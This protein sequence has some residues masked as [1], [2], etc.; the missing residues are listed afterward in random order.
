[1]SI[2]S[3]C[4]HRL[5][6][7]C[8]GDIQAITDIYNCYIRLTDISFETDELT[9]EQ[10][11]QRIDSIAAEYPY[12]VAE[13]NGQVVGY[14]YAHPWKERAAYS[15]TLETTVYVAPSHH[16]QGIGRQLMLR[17]IDDCRQQGYHALIACITA[18]NDASIALHTTLGFMQ[19][20]SFKDVGY[21]FGRFIDVVDYELL[22]G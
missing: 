14:C 19:V 3:K 10:M 4:H 11:G 13:D 21:K 17:L 22:L 7:I 6:N 15:A 16:R 1:M 2:S 8:H 18:D 5:R 12:I 20:S 9:T